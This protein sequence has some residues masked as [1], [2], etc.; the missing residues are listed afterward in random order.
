MKW[1]G[2]TAMV[3]CVGLMACNASNRGGAEAPTGGA[4]DEAEELREKNMSGPR[5][6]G[7]ASCPSAVPGATTEVMNAPDGVE[8]MITS[9]EKGGARQIQFL[10][11]RLAELRPAADEVR[12]SG[13][14]TGGGKL[15]YCPVVIAGTDLVVED[16]AG[17]ARVVV[18]ARHPELVGALQEVTRARADALSRGY[19]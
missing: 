3:F 19:K 17:G 18:R 10:A 15:G 2:A 14:G 4:E 1:V 13:E 12:H 8:L 6:R 16:V 5:T 7:L 9:P 11:R